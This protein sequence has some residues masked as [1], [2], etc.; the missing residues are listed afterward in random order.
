MAPTSAEANILR[1]IS[2][3]H[4]TLTNGNAQKIT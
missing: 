2:A 1:S 3:M 4:L